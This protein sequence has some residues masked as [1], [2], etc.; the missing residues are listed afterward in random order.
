MVAALWSDRTA[1]ARVH[2]YSGPRDLRAP[3]D[4]AVCRV[5]TVFD[6]THCRRARLQ[7]GGRLCAGTRSQHVGARAAACRS[8]I[9]SA[10]PAATATA[11]LDSIRRMNERRSCGA[12]SAATRRS[13]MTRRSCYAVMSEGFVPLARFLRPP[14]PEPVVFS[15]PQ[16]PQPASRSHR[17]RIRRRASSSMPLRSA[18]FAVFAPP[19][20]THWTLRWSGFSRRSPRTCWRA[21]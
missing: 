19:W 20:A 13:S 15:L 1:R 9:I 14:P 5:L 18:R 3:R 11:V 10:L 7:G 17:A 16:V 2:L 21:S 4:A 8:G 12:C 6:R